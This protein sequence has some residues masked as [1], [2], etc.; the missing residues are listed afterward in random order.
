LL[1]NASHEA[2]LIL[3]YENHYQRW[4]AQIAWYADPANAGKSLPQRKK[5]NKSLAIFHALYTYQDGGQQKNG[6]WK[7]AGITRY[8]VLF[9]DYESAKYSNY[10]EM[11]AGLRANPRIVVPGI[12]K[13]EWHD[14][15]ANFLQ[16]LRAELNIQVGVEGDNRRRGN[17]NEPV[18]EQAV[19]LGIDF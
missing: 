12:V 4:V 8:N 6:A 15:E 13:Q 17:R 2:F 19:P 18:E 3:L 11:Q 14:L 9:G 10:G 1:F 7:T 16:R 5:A